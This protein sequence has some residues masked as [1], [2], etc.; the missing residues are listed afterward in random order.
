[1]VSLS[2][3]V[4]LMPSRCAPSRSVVSKTW[5]LSSGRSFMVVWL[6]SDG[7]GATGISG[8]APPMVPHAPHPVGWSG[9]RKDPSRVREVCARVRGTVV[10][11]YRVVRGDHCGPARLLP[12]IMANESTEAVK[13]KPP[14]RSHPSQNASYRPFEGSADQT[15]SPGG[16]A[17]RGGRGGGAGR[18]GQPP[19]L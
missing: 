4:R 16:A 3:T 17:S 12:I 1:M 19:A 13:H 14:P 15:I 7:S 2:A 6:L 9:K 8:S 11:S 10:A 5:K 18:V